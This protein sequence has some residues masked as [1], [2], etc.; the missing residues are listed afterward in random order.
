M[1]TVNTDLQDHLQSFGLDKEKW[2][3]ELRD[4]FGITFVSQL[5]HLQKGELKKIESLALHEWEKAALKKMLSKK[6]CDKMQELRKETIELKSDILTSDA[7]QSTEIKIRLEKLLERMQINKT[8]ITMPRRKADLDSFVDSLSHQMD[9]LQDTVHRQPLTNHEVIENASGGLALSGLYQIGH[10]QNY[11]RTCTLLELKNKEDV[12]FKQSCMTQLDKTETFDDFTKYEEFTRNVETVGV[13]FSGNLKASALTA[14]VEIGACYNKQDEK[15]TSDQKNIHSTSYCQER[16]STIP[17]KSFEMTPEMVCFTKS[18]ETKLKEIEDLIILGSPTNHIQSECLAFFKSFGA[19]V[20]MG[21]LEFGGTYRWKATYKSEN[22]CVTKETR[23]VVTHSLNGYIAGSASFGYKSVGCAASGG[24][25][26]EEGKSQV[27]SRESEKKNTTLQ[28]TKTGGPTE[29]DNY[30]I[31]RY[32]LYSL[33]STWSLIDRGTFVGIWDIVDTHT[34]VFSDR[35]NLSRILREAWD[36]RMNISDFSQDETSHRDLKIVLQEMREWAY[37]P[38]PDVDKCYQILQKLNTVK[39]KRLEGLEINRDSFF[40]TNTTVKSFFQKIVEQKE[41]FDQTRG[42]L[43]KLS[44]RQILHPFV[45]ENFPECISVAAWML[46]DVEQDRDLKLSDQDQQMAELEIKAYNMINTLAVE[47]R[48]QYPT[49]DIFQRFSKEWI[50]VA[51]DYTMNDAS[52]TI[53]TI[54]HDIDTQTPK[55]QMN[56]PFADCILMPVVD[57]DNMQ[58]LFR[59]LKLKPKASKCFHNTSSSPNMWQPF[60]SDHQ[61]ILTT[62][63]TIFESIDGEIENFSLHTNTKFDTKLVRKL[64]NIIETHTGNHN[65]T[66]VR[67]FS[68]Y[69]ETFITLHTS[70]YLKKKLSD[71]HLRYLDNFSLKSKAWNIFCVIVKSATDDSIAECYFEHA[72]SDAISKHILE[73]IPDKVTEMMLNRFRHSKRYLVECILTDLANQNKFDD[74]LWYIHHPKSFVE[75]YLKNVTFEKKNDTTGFFKIAEHQA[76]TVFSKVVDVIYEFDKSKEVLTVPQFAKLL[77]RI[78]QIRVGIAI[79]RGTFSQVELHLQNHRK[80][81]ELVVNRIPYIK[82]SVLQKFEDIS[83]D[84]VKWEVNPYDKMMDVLW[85][86]SAKCPLCSEPCMTSKTEH[87]NDALHRCDFHRVIGVSGKG[88]CDSLCTSLCNI[89]SCNDFLPLKYAKQNSFLRMLGHGRPTISGWDLQPYTQTSTNYWKWFCCTYKQCLEKE[90]CRY[91]DI[92]D[93]WKTI[94]KDDAIQS[95]RVAPS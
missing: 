91:L 29:V 56:K 54:H 52:D 58:K 33:N 68:V 83:K 60:E 84:T 17:V 57:Y 43:F 44:M 86:C 47:L 61:A 11:K 94:S 16:S 45:A 32:G 26:T 64:F 12:C 53:Q 24:Y 51:K 74:Y 50:I 6:V 19:F 72:L 65:T 28:I 25:T 23:E 10:Q 8:E 15:E 55:K 59:S 90:Y 4:N 79:S 92:S 93:H 3:K 70:L 21:I 88:F 2:T 34:S 63:N 13:K 40:V 69:L 66:S 30:F 77:R 85:G 37:N 20:N 49:E 48:G 82:K 78:L 38:T 36:N 80:F 9:K 46:P 73:I 75:S 67:K 1:E 5:Q 95:I 14:S 89:E 22:S 71:L 7:E 41:C 31:W 81:I 39:Q 27:T 76:D 42:Q 35:K 62:T 18:A 87:L